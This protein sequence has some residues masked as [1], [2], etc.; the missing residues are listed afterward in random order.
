MTSFEIISFYIYALSRGY[1]LNKQACGSFGN[2][3][4]AVPEANVLTTTLLK[5]YF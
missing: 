5:Q 3:E 1:L 2:Q 4:L